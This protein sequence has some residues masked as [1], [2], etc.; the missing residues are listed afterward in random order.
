MMPKTPLVACFAAVLLTGCQGGAARW[1]GVKPAEDTAGWARTRGEVATIDWADLEPAALEQPLLV[2]AE[3]AM[4]VAYFDRTVWIEAGGLA[5]LG[6][7]PDTLYVA[8]LEGRI[9]DADHPRVQAGPGRLLLWTPASPLAR[10]HVFEAE[11]LRASTPLVEAPLAEEALARLEDRQR[12]RRFWGNLR[13]TGVNAVASTPH[14]QNQQ[15]AAYLQNDDVVDLRFDPAGPDTLALR[16]AEAFV[17][18]LREGDSER[19]AR[20]LSPRLGVENTPQAQATGFSRETLAEA[21]VARDWSGL[22][23]AH[24]VA[25]ERPTDFRVR[26]AEAGYRLALTAGD[27]LFYV[28]EIN[29]LPAPEQAS[30]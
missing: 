25:T 7:S 20:L 24:V 13:G 8:C 18:A 9:A 23:G 5:I 17:E 14:E 4:A 11:H 16:V 29:R 2:R 15:R 22:D 21:M 3:E 27:G 12:G 30:R 28:T 19:V 26:S 6:V 10:S 1:Q